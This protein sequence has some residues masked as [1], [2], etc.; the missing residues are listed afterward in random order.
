M[1][2]ARGLAFVGACFALLAAYPGGGA[3]ASTATASA[4]ASKSAPSAASLA[5]VSPRAAAAVSEA[6][7]PVTA[8]E[9]AASD[10]AAARPGHRSIDLQRRNG[11]L[12]ATATV[13][14]VSPNVGPFSGGTTIDITGTDFTTATDVLFGSTDITASCPSAGGCFDITDD[15][16]ITAVTPPETA[17]AQD[18]TVTNDMGPGSPNPPD[19][20]FTWFDQPTVTNVDSP[21]N[22]GATGIA[23]TGNNFSDP[24]V[25]GDAVTDVALNPT[26]AG[27]T[28]NL[29]TACATGTSPD[30]FAFAD[31][32]DLTINLPASVAPGQYDVEVTTPGGTS[33]Q[34]SNDFLVVQQA[35]PT[36]TSVTPDAGPSAG[37]TTGVAI[38]GTGFEGSGFATSDVFVGG[39][40]LSPC[41]HAGGCFTLNSATSITL[42]TPPGSGQQDVTVET[43]STDGTAI[44]T[45]NTNAADTFAYAPVPAIS[46][47]VQPNG[48]TL[49]GNN[50]TLNGTG[51]ESTNGTGANFTTTRVSVGT[52]NI[53]STPCPGTPVAACYTINSATQIV[54]KDFPAHAAGPVLIT[55]T[56]AGGTSSGA[57]YM[58]V[59]LPTVTSVSPSSGPT[60]GGGLVTVTGTAFANATDVFV[61]GND[62][63]SSDFTVNGAGTQISVPNWPSHAAGGPFDVTVETPAPGGT[64]APSSGDQYTYIPPPT[65]TGVAPQAGPTGGGNTVTVVGT[66]F[67]GTTDVQVGTNDVTASPCSGSPSSP[68]FTVNGAGTQITIEDMPGASAG[69]PVDITVNTPDGSNNPTP[70]DTYVYAPEPTVTA[71]AP[72]AGTLAGGNS[73]TVTGTGFSSSN[74]GSADFTVT[75]V[76]IGGTAVSTTCG[77]SPC[78][79]V[80]DSTHV[81]VQVP[82]ESAGTVNVTVTTQG[83]TSGPGSYTYAP[84]PTISSISP[85]AGPV[86][87]G[88]AVTI[89]GTGFESGSA[90]TTTQVTVGGTP[91]TTTCGSSP[92][93][94]VV[95]ASQITVDVPPNAGG[96]VPITVTTIGGTSTAAQYAYAPAP[97]VTGVS[98]NAGAL[99]G[100][101]PVV[102]TGTAFEFDKRARHQLCGHIRH[103]RNRDLFDLVFRREQPDP[104]HDYEYSCRSRRRYCRY[105]GDDSGRHQRDD[106][107]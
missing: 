64:S 104:D 100:G 11:P 82:A 33:N 92:C 77:S 3:V 61:G 6:T 91:V 8:F 52:T 70:A 12:D 13:S 58:Y 39:T 40:D 27:S 48:P 75:A 19:D 49:G 47:V 97:T 20:Q 106:I 57:S 30:C 96:T 18:I 65:V 87:G 7:V 74:G 86:A 81:T 10:V 50:V 55:V 2:R 62:I 35:D 68:C 79:T 15:T 102:I 37:G 67:A 103:G 90:F 94:T 95:S 73:I 98:P 43:Q 66:A 60:A 76:T 83:G 5:S 71:V 59:A 80:V 101:T 32:N 56:T 26:G 78:F 107:E 99:S 1:I 14:E 84:V 42:T 16:D 89:N 23:V 28:V 53:T 105:H 45:S 21:Q 88:T 63:P 38:V 36:V 51:F 24:A 72:S 4:S 34:S 22:E 25:G 69:S 31:D 54:V 93:F 44:Q 17:G 41:P 29:T 9:A 85:L 46:G